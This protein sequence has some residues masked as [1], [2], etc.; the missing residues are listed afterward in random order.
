MCEFHGRIVVVKYTD[1]RHTIRYHLGEFVHDGSKTPKEKFGILRSLEVV[2]KTVIDVEQ[3]TSERCFD[4]LSVRILRTLNC[5]LGMF[6]GVSDYLL[7]NHLIVVL[8]ERI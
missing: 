2:L 6:V 7:L 5:E 1:P 4:T 8:Y 3:R